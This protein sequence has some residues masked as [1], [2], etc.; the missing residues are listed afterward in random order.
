M[1]RIRNL[2]LAA[3]LMVLA[4]CASGPVVSFGN[5]Q[6]GY[7]SQL[8]EPGK[9]YTIKRRNEPR[10]NQVYVASED[11]TGFVT[12]NGARYEFDDIELIQQ[13]RRRSSIK[14][15]AAAA[16]LMPLLLISC[17]RDNVNCMK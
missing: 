14:G 12:G 7:A 8:I 10:G 4:G 5:L 9:T 13:Q 2:V 16:V 6:P 3:G 11:A 17:S 15:I 1:D